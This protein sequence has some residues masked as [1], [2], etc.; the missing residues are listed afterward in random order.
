MRKNRSTDNIINITRGRKRETMQQKK[1]KKLWK[2]KNK[3][4][5]K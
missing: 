1:K 4:R 3:I 5:K 2:T